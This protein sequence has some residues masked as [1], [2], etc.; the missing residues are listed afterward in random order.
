[1]RMAES[2]SRQ[3]SGCGARSGCW[4]CVRVGKDQSAEQMIESDPEL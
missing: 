3:K 2:A 4:T 1:M